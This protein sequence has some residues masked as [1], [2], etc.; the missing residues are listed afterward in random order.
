MSESL[1]KPEGGEGRD[2]QDITLSSVAPQVLVKSKLSMDIIVEWKESRVLSHH[3][4]ESN[5]N[6][7]EK[8]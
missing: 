7:I 5:L 4:I 3:Q 6:L 8:D 2:I 1:V